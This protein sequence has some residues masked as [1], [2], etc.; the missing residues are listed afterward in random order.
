[1]T[2][3]AQQIRAA[4]GAT[5]ALAASFG[6]GRA[7]EQAQTPRPDAVEAV[8]RPADA[9]ETPKAIQAQ[10]DPEPTAPAK[11]ERQTGVEKRRP[12]DL[13]E[14]TAFNSV[15]EQTDDTP[16]TSADGSDIC[17]RY[18]AGELICAANFVPFGTRLA[19]PGYGT[20]TV[21]D[22]LSRRFPERVDIYLGTD[23]TAARRWGLRR[24]DI[25]ISP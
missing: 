1:M 23:I 2:N 17:A 22:R 14:V 16:C 25:E 3:P 19:V 10:T 8:I 13:R 6:T 15:P 24:L 12:T 7:Y 9:P 21:A 5:L 4:I 18:A 20:C 11:A